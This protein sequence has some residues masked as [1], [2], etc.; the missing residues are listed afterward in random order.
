MTCVC[1]ASV[2]AQFDSIEMAEAKPDLLV[3]LDG[4]EYQLDTIPRGDSKVVLDEK[5]KLLGAIDLKTL[6]DDLGRVGAFIRIAYNGVGAAGHRFTEL[7]IEIQRL[8]YDVTKLCDKSALTVSKFKKASATVLTDLQATYGFLLDN[9][10]DMAVETL[11]NVSKIAGDMEKAAIELHKEFE[12]EEKK[13]KTALE[14]TQRAKGEEAQRIIDK[15]K[16]RDAFEEKRKEQLELMNDA[17]RLEREAE[18]Q[19]RQIE[20]KEEA[21]IGDIGNP[22]KTLFNSLTSLVGIKVFDESAPEKQAKMLKERRLD[23][24]KKANEFRQQRYEAM[25]RMTSFAS[26]IKECQTEQN[27]AEAAAEALHEAIGALKELS[28]VMMQVA[29]FWKQMQDHC[30]SLAED[31][32]TKQVQKAMKDYSDEKR[33]KLW[34][35]KPFKI[36]AVRFYA[37]WVALNGVCSLYVEHI[38]LVQKD[39]YAYLRENPT[40]EESRR[41][42]RELADKFLTDLK[43]DQKAI[44]EKEF[45]A[46]EEIKALSDQ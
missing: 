24:L 11:T 45:A 3:D 22:L 31:H 43:R 12:E 14:K 34:T 1:A 23:A 42:V 25:S 17:Q 27:M 20:L 7:Q 15:A 13:V 2:H 29:M 4:E 21:A 9:F 36:Q 32:M 10:E 18:A 16:E 38:K 28:V 5:E 26:K 6:V 41:N 39:L 35:S 30:K 33:L 44:A 8:G 40:Y 46:E 37:G 19:Q